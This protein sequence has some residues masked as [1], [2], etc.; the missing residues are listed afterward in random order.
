MYGHLSCDVPQVLPALVVTPLCR[1]DGE[2][3]ERSGVSEGVW[4]NGDHMQSGPTFLRVYPR[5]R[6]R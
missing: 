4:V 6:R 1:H 2:L 5:V 3:Q